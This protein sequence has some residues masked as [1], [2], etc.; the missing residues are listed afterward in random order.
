MS[1]RSAA[2]RSGLG[3]A[4]ALGA[5]ILLA[6][7]AGPTASFSAEGPCT[8]DGRAPG[9][10]PDL[11]ARLP[12]ALS[13]VSPDNGTG[14]ATS[15]D[16]PTIVDSGRNCT[17]EVLG[18]LWDHG[19]RELRFAGAIWDIGGG[20]GVV[21]ALFM[22]PSGQPALDKA[23]LEEFY[24]ASARASSKAENITVTRQTIDPAGEVFRIDALN[25]L[26][27][28]TVVVWPDDDVV[29]LAIVATNVE[30]GADRSEHEGAV[31]LVVSQT[32]SRTDP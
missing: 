30:P 8:V 22:T 26:S 32:A 15:D 27:L 11:E 18:T 28:Q 3:V 7:C 12:A 1:F 29:R 16:A 25:D 2:A 6:A 20:E 9:G 5:S 17:Q 19:V 31:Q 10:Y 24:E 4:F 21:T 13:G 23:W 14:G